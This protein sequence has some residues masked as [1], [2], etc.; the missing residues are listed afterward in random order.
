MRNLTW[1]V[2][3]RSQWTTRTQDILGQVDWLRDGRGA[4]YRRTCHIKDS[5]MVTTG[6]ETEGAKDWRR[7]TFGMK[8]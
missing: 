7:K 3:I 1:R 4:G 8:R 6:A 5:L 2:A